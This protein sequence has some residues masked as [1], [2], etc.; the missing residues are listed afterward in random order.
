MSESEF[1]TTQRQISEHYGV[2]L[3]T[4]RGW[5][6]HHRE[7]MPGEAGKYSKEA[8]DAWI[9]RTL[10]NSP[11][12]RMGDLSDKSSVEIQ[13]LRNEG[14]ARQS[15]AKAAILERQNERQEA[16]VV[17]KSDVNAFL[18]ELFTEIKRNVMRIG[19]ELAPGYPSKIRDQLIEDI[20]ARHELYLRGLHSHAKRLE[21][22]E[23]VS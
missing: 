20:E 17:L 1:W 19:Q 15:I 23:L 22:L 9:Q 4:V 16:E 3:K 13:Q 18:A 7:P 11:L 2:S 10:R 12:N 14:D 21:E 8:I 6:S 5:L